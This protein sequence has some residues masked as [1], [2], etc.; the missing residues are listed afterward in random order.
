MLH[1]KLTCPNHKRYDP[2]RDGE[3]AIRGNC[4]YCAAMYNLYRTYIS[5]L[6]ALKLQ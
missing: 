2:A 4:K 5:T 6:I 3:G 1:L